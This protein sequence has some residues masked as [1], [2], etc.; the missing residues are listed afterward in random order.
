[1]AAHAGFGDTKSSDKSEDSSELLYLRG[2]TPLSGRI[3]SEGRPGVNRLEPPIFEEC[4]I[5]PDLVPMIGSVPGA[6]RLGAGLSSPLRDANVEL[7]Y[8]RLLRGPR[9]ARR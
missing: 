5:P 9:S 3:I 8:S 6:L 2:S 7:R 1:M 4:K